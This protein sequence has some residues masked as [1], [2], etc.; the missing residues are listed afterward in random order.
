[1]DS[2]QR[3][4]PAL[5]R[6]ARRVLRNEEDARDVV[7]NLFLDLLQRPNVPLDLPFLY[8]T[9]THRCLNLLRDEKNRLRLLERE[10]PA[11]RGPVRIQADTQTLGLD[12]LCKLAQRVE[13]SVMETLVFRYFDEMGLQ[14]I[15]DVTSVSR[16]TVQNRLN[17]AAEALMAL[18]GEEGAG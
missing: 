7:Q 10:S 5:L 17:R 18:S 15:A 16:K 13:E 8:R 14:E 11:L 12:V 9:L 3:Y 2:Y 6:K 4:G 1:M